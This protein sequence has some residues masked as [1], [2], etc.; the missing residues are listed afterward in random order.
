MNPYLV[1]LSRQLLHALLEEADQ[2]TMEQRADARADLMGWVDDRE[3][4]RLLRMPT[5]GRIQ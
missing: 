1:A 5:S 3:K 4:D 2:M